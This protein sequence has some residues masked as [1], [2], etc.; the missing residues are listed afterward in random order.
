[1]HPVLLSNFIAD[2][3]GHLPTYIETSMEDDTND[4]FVDASDSFGSLFDSAHPDGVIA[5]LATCYQALQCEFQTLT[6]H[7]DELSQR[8]TESRQV[9][10]PGNSTNTLLHEL[11]ASAKESMK[12]LE[13]LPPELF[14][15]RDARA[16]L[17]LL[18][19]RLKHLVELQAATNRLASER[20]NACELKLQRIMKMLKAAEDLTSSTRGS[21]KQRRGRSSFLLSLLS[22]TMVVTLLLVWPLAAERG[23]GWLW[24]RCFQRLWRA[25]ILSPFWDILIHKIQT[26]S[27]YWPR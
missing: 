6:S 26:L 18:R 16:K 2:F 14:V 13:S 3:T 27:V 25:A 21:G 22:G 8:L 10:A 4:E 15:V 19:D 12:R 1:V 9:L 20:D 7:R 11:N 23:W 5:S 17:P 24:E